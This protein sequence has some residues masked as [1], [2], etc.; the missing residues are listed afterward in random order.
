M[1]RLWWYRQHRRAVAA[2]VTAGAVGWDETIKPRKFT[3]QSISNYFP[4]P[5]FTE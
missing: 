2:V 3:L 4:T 1:H 5:F